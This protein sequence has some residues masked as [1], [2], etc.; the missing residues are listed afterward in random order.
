MTT[1]TETPKAFLD[2]IGA[3]LLALI[4][5]VASVTLI[6][7]LNK[8]ELFADQKNQSSA[9]MFSAYEG[10]RDGEY[11]MLADQAASNPDKW[12]AEK[13]IIAKQAANAMCVKKTATQSGS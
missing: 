12:T 8:A 5:L 13:M 11:K 7:H 3:R 9:G 1:A 10:C 6:V 2:S 4:C